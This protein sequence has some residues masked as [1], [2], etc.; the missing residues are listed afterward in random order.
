MGVATRPAVAQAGATSAPAADRTVRPELVNQYGWRPAG[1]PGVAQPM[2]HHRGT[3]DHGRGGGPLS[4]QIGRHPPT[5]SPRRSGIVTDR[6]SDA[7]LSRSSAADATSPDASG[8][9][10]TN[11]SAGMGLAA[12]PTSSQETRACLA[13]MYTSS[14]CTVSAA[15]RPCRRLRGQP[16]HR[17]HDPAHEPVPP[18]CRRPTR[19]SHAQRLRTRDSQQ[20]AARSAGP[21]A[22]SHPRAPPT[23]AERA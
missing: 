7:E 17:M 5:E 1:S 11:R 8:R 23:R 12:V 14:G 13:H 16:A 6:R 2:I 3:K 15:G 9:N 18:V 22:G 19:N 21:V 4:S 20:R 10:E